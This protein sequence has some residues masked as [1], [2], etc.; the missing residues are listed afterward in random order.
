MARQADVERLYTFSRAILLIEGVES[1][2]RELVRQLAE[3]FQLE[4]VVLFDRRSGDASARGA[5]TGCRLVFYWK[6]ASCF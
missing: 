3:V 2:P 4:A 1:F 6:A 5:G